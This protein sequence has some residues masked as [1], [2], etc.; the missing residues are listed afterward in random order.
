MAGV[1]HHAAAGDADIPVRNGIG[2]ADMRLV[3]RGNRDAAA[4]ATHRGGTLALGCTGLAA[5]A[6]RLTAADTEP[7]AAGT[8]QTGF[9]L[10][11][12]APGGIGVSR[13]HDIDVKVR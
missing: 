7:D 8:H 10:F 9:F 5:V 12:K 1:N 13:C 2:T 6:G 4:G 3:T 11:L